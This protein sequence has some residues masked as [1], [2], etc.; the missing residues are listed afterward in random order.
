[1]K[2]KSRL[3]QRN[4]IGQFRRSYWWHFAPLIYLIVSIIALYI[5]QL[6]YTSKELIDPCNGCSFNFSA[7]AYESHE[8]VKEV[9]E[10]PKTQKEQIIAYITE[11]FGEEAPNAFNILYCENRGLRPDAINHNRNGSIDEGIFQINSI[12]GQS[13]M[14]N[15]KKNIDFAYKLF[16]RGGWSQWSCS[17]RVDIT[18]FYLK[19]AN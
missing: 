19:G 7:R 5:L 6:L 14:L 9:I 10:T 8:I 15:W 11:V 3:K 17:H 4:K 1:M 2:T 16:K 18:P 13:D 12:H